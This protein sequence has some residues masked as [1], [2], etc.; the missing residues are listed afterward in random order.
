MFLHQDN[1]DMVA[2]QAIEVIGMD[3]GED[4][5]TTT[6]L[7][8]PIIT[9]S[10]PMLEL[11]A[12]SVSLSSS[13][14]SS[15]PSSLTPGQPA[16]STAPRLHQ[17]QQDGCNK[18]EALEILFAMLSNE[19]SAPTNTV[20]RVGL[21]ET[22]YHDIMS[23]SSFDDGSTTAEN[24]PNQVNDHDR[25]KMCEWYYEMS[26]FLKIDRATASRSLA[27]LDRFMAI[28]VNDPTLQASCTTVAPPPPSFTSEANI[29]VAQAVIAASKHRDVYQLVAL[30]ALFLAIKLF[31]RLSVEPS[32]A[33]Y[34]SRGRYTAQEVVKMESIMLHAL[35]WKVCSADKVDFVNAYLDV[36]WPKKCERSNNNSDPH[37]Q[38]HYLLSSFKDLSMMQIQV[39]DYDSSFASMKPSCVALAAVN[40]AL[41]FKKEDMSPEDYRSILK[42]LHGLANKLFCSHDGMETDN[43]V[44][45]RNQL[46]MTMERLRGV[47]DP[48]V[49]RRSIDYSSSCRGGSTSSMEA[50]P[51]STS[52]YER[53]HFSPSVHSDDFSATASGDT[54]QQYVA[55]SP[56]DV[57]LESIENFDV[58]QLFC[59]GTTQHTIGPS[60]RNSTRYGGNND[61]VADSKQKGHSSRHSVRITDSPSPTSIA[62]TTRFG[63]R[64]L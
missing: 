50:S 34:L 42:S 38:Y 36:V 41:E 33:S 22:P 26:E 64:L 28:P 37:Q 16:A 21:V 20:Q 62:S 24:D 59:C 52:S 18:D 7:S 39:S 23:P 11:S 31:E 60:L 2:M 53:Y 51:T 25:S 61:I 3:D 10:P 35:E 43:T 1:D 63:A 45:E 56:L 6:S 55:V 15:S 44:L 47:I 4:N 40:N 48:T 14:S 12:T 49:V 58:T 17:L 46:A 32:H 19:R 30:T 57:A 8:V 9:W 54:Q 27:L 29:T 5:I 13:S